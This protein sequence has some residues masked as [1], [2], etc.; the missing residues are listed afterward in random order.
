MTTSQIIQYLPSSNYVEY[1]RG[2]TDGV[3]GAT[4]LATIKWEDDVERDSWVKIY[5]GNKPRSLINEMIGYLLGRALNLPMP[6]R[7]GFLLLENKMLNPSFVNVLSEVDRYRGFTF[8][9]VSE[10]V[11]GKNLRI[12]I[13]NNPNAMKVML[14]YFSS[15]MKDWSHL[16][17]LIAFDDWILNTDRNMGNSIHLPDKTFS[18]IDHGECMHGGNWKEAQL[19]DFNCPHMGFAHNLH[20]R[21]LHE[22]H[23][24]SGLFQYENTMQELEKAKLEHKNAFLQAEAEIRLHLHDLIGD[25]VIETGIEEIPSYLAL[26]TV[27]NFLKYRAEGLTKFSERCDTFLSS[28]S[29]VRP[30]S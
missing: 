9:W 7:A 4:H 8:A 12:E 17:N 10:D 30:L 3:S 24:A 21:L 14:E 2:S 25:E 6:P 11:K 20:L 15:C 13:E 16:S 29:I 19:I 18:L 1:L 22:K 27:L 23:E 26:E 28:H 5:A